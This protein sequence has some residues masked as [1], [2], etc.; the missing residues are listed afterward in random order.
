MHHISAKNWL[1]GWSPNYW[2]V[3]IVVLGLLLVAPLFCVIYL[4]NLVLIRYFG[5]SEL[6]VRSKARWRSLLVPLTA[7]NLQ[8]ED[9]VDRAA[10]L[11]LRM[12]MPQVVQEVVTQL[13][14]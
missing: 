1:E 9:Y 6:A 12:S 4:L 13:V 5:K 8:P 7:S 14:A 3:L 10:I 11:Q 2:Q